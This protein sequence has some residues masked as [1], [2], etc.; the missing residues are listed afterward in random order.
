VATITFCKARR[1][2]DRPDAMSGGSISPLV[3]QT[4]VKFGRHVAM[5][6]AGEKEKA[7]IWNSKAVPR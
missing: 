7:R 3:R 1:Q 6:A 2:A 5:N 4:K